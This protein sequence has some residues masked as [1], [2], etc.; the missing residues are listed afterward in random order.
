MAANDHTVILISYRK[1]CV[2]LVS[3]NLN[4]LNYQISQGYSIIC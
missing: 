2:V 4:F 1:Y 3:T